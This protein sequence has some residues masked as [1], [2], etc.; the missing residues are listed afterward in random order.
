MIHF[1]FVVSDEDAENIFGCISSEINRCN[2]DLL[3]LVMAREFFNR[4]EDHKYADSIKDHIAYL[5]E[6][7]LKMN[8]TYRREV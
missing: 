8:N 3:K 7:K 6:L 5:K 4:D 2:D 1:D